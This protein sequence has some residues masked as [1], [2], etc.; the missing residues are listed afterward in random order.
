MRFRSI[1]AVAVIVCVMGWAVAGQ[2]ISRSE[3]K[4]TAVRE[5][6]SGISE[7]LVEQPSGPCGWF[8][9][10][11]C[12]DR[13]PTPEPTGCTDERIEKIDSRSEGYPHLHYLGEPIG[14][15]VEIDDGCKR[16]FEGGTI[17]VTYRSKYSTV[18]AGPIRD[19]YLL[20]GECAGDLGWPRSSMSERPHKDAPHDFALI[21]GA[22]LADV[23][24]DIE[25]L[26]YRHQ[27]DNG[28]VYWHPDHDAP[29]VVMDRLHDSF[30]AEG[31]TPELGF[32]IND[33][34]VDSHAGEV[35]FQAF[36]DALIFENA[37]GEMEIFRDEMLDLYLDGASDSR[38]PDSVD[39]PALAETE[40]GLPTTD[41]L[42]TPNGFVRRL[43]RGTIYYRDGVALQAFPESV[44][45][46]DGRVMDS[47]A[48]PTSG[49]MWLAILEDPY[50]PD[51][52]KNV[53]SQALQHVGLCQDDARDAVGTSAKIYCSEFVREIY[54]AAGVDSS[55]WGGGIFL[56]SV[57]YAPQLR[58]IFARNSRFV[59][60]RDAN[61]LTP[62]PGDYLSMYD[63]GHSALVVATCLDG[64]YLWRVGGNE[65]PDRC[66]RFSRDDFYFDSGAMNGDFY[67]FGKL[68]ASFS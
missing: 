35:L 51:F 36:E 20:L 43:H 21:S 10:E 41:Y 11:N 64:R 25:D 55:L 28:W 48:E 3:V 24:Y 60:A 9:P 67:G 8:A 16:D 32:P 46:I 12:P 33:T 29:H 52:R 19:L 1:S 2:A 13:E 50:L 26:A 53:M 17:Y 47:E 42:P 56:W 39:D 4:K 23:G 68:D 15:Y 5:S 49:E 58:W 66:V 40:L 45:V 62:E 7:R 27:F 6:P 34:G 63:E 30:Q 59:Y 57:T 38:A 65:A 61:E 18:V 54:M 44:L 31:G 14:G 37:L 22:E